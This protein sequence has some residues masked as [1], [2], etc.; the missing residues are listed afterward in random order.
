M[1]RIEGRPQLQFAQEPFMQ[2]AKAFL[3]LFAMAY[4]EV[5]ADPRELAPDWPRYA[6]IEQAG[7]IQF[8]TARFKG[9]PVGYCVVMVAPDLHH[10]GELV[11]VSDVVYMN[12]KY[13]NGFSFMRFLDFIQTSLA[14][15]GVRN[16]DIHEK[17][18]HEF[19]PILMKMGYTCKEKAWHKQLR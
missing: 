6:A 13:R 5:E 8:F 10:M 15:K 3:R 11:S 12:P 7:M 4:D 9:E 1:R 19:S 18:C 14:Q 16:L 17:V 2:N